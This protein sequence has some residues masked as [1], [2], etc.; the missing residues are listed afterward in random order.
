MSSLLTPLADA[1]S[2]VIEESNKQARRVIASQE[3]QSGKQVFETIKTSDD[4]K[5]V[6]F[7]EFK[8]TLLAKL[9]A[10]ETA[11][12]DYVKSEILSAGETISDEEMEALKQ[13]HK[14]AKA[15]VKAAIDLAKMQP[16]Y[17]TAWEEA[18]PA[19]LTFRKGAAVGST[20]GTK[21]PRLDSAK[22]DGVDFSVT[23]KSAKGEVTE[24]VTFTAIA[25]ELIK[26]EKA[27]GAEVKITSADLI[28]AATS[29]DENWQ[30]SDSVEFVWTGKTQN[31]T[32]VV[33]PKQTETE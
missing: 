4:P 9:E 31:Y 3:R 19:M 7:R 24:G 17:N 21:R 23:R 27:A 11:I 22:I 25:L 5:V 6:K 13:A 20:S 15:K 33:F 2:Q 14:N 30:S 8:D 26:R 32:I 12:S 18:L 10:A 28:A 16:D 1:I 29:T